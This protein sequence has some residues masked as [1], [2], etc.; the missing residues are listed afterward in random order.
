MREIGSGVESTTSSL[1]VGNDIVSIYVF[2]PE[3]LIE[4]ERE[5][6]RALGIDDKADDK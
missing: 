5:S 1:R 2:W 3:R 4:A 6:E